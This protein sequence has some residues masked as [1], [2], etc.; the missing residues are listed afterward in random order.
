MDLFTVAASLIMASATLG[1][2]GLLASLIVMEQRSR[3]GLRY[4][5]CQPAPPHSP[6]S[7]LVAWPAADRG[8]RLARLQRQTG[9]AKNRR[10][11]CLQPTLM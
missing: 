11:K 6:Q 1:G 8:N 9:K 5:A 10:H 7:A 4:P 2:F 3:H